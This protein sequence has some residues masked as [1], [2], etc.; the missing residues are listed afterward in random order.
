MILKII[1]VGIIL[2]IIGM[3]I[4]EIFE[5]YDVIEVMAGVFIIISF[6][7]AIVLLMWGGAKDG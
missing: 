2:T 7:S 3:F 5:R 1:F 6:I 4:K